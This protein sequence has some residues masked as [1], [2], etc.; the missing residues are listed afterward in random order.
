MFVWVYYLLSCSI[1]TLFSS[2]ISFSNFTHAL[3]PS[4][5]PHLHH[6]LALVVS[7]CFNSF[8]P[9]PFPCCCHPRVSLPPLLDLWIGCPLLS[10]EL[11]R[12][13]GLMSLDA[14]SPTIFLNALLVGSLYKRFVE[15]A[16]RCRP[17][18]SSLAKCVGPIVKSIL[19]TTGKVRGVA[20][21]GVLNMLGLA[22]SS[23]DEELLS[24]VPSSFVLRWNLL[25]PAIGSSHFVSGTSRRAPLVEVLW[26]MNS[27][28]LGFF[29]LL[30]SETC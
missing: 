20:P 22:S 21:G 8:S 24:I 30:P 27:V 15:P 17:I 6:L 10:L 4:L 5:H 26:W 12:L 29:L 1:A 18:H 9:C 7:F 28:V 19:V 25:S 16:N 11:R 3:L 23:S 2:V 14:L 13:L